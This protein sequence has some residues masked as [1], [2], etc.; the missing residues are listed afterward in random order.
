MET[1]QVPDCAEAGQVNRR[2]FLITAGLAG[3]SLFL[4]CVVDPAETLASGGEVSGKIVSL[5]AWVKIGTDDSVT[6]VVSQAEMGQGIRTTLPAVLAE[7]LGADWSR[8]RLEDSPTDPAYRNPR[9]NWQFTGNSESTPSFF[10]L[11]RQMGA[12]ARE[13]LIQAAAQRWNVDPLACRTEA[14]K[15]VHSRSHR[16][17]RFGEL[18]EAA[19]KI[20]PPAKPTLKSEK[21][22]TLLGKALPR[23]ENPNKVEGSAIFGL[24]FSL[25]GL[26]YA[27]VR[28]CPVFGGDVASVDRSSI[29]GF[30]GVIDVVR[31]P[32]GIAVVGET[33]WQAKLAL[34]ALNV[35]FSEGPAASVG[36]ESLRDDYR[37]AMEGNEWLL[38]HAEGNADALHHDYPNVPLTKDTIPIISS[39]KAVREMY[40][41]IYSQ[42]YESQFLAH[43][44]M[45][46][47]NCTARVSGDSVEIWAPTQGQELTRLTLAAVFKLPKENIQV[48]RTLLGGG[49]GRRLVAD[50]ALQAALVSKGVG[51]PVKVIWSREEDVQ[52]DIYRP[53]T[54]HRI[55]AGID[56]YGKLR[57]IAHRLV[58][59][60]ILEYVFAQAVTDVYDPSCLEGL[61][62]SHYE[63]PNVR[64]DFKLLH[65]PVPTSVLRTTGYGPNI[66][67]FESFIDELASKK[68]IDPYH[69]RR[70]LLGKSSRSLAVL[71]LAAK[72][73]DWETPAPKGHYRG[74]A[75]TEAFG[76]HLAH[77]VELSVLKERQVKI[78]K[79]ICVADPGTALDPDI[80]MNSL[81]GGI[82]WGLSCAFKSEITFERGRTVQSNWH[83]YSVLR[84]SEMPPVEVHLINSGA[85]PLGG[86]GEV[87]PITVVPAVT[88]AIF[89]A[90][91]MRFRSLP[92]SKHGFSLA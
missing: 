40:P 73:S 56:E 21:E 64:V 8:I 55:T 29:A 2:Q 74:I 7:E 52:H 25:P 85:R 48:S 51:R 10:E 18:V 84:M 34:D 13:M 28:Q 24:D 72:K 82:A 71:D 33:Y 66:F 88:N 39:M 62:E 23:V 50:F 75:Y 20:T 5:N 57:A 83:D 60:S 89:A 78:H 31:I 4:K 19:A 26:A 87:G 38:V 35:S 46:P 53:A 47:M 27:A 36:S 77:V 69:Y 79:I 6:I 49:F 80:T 15:V 44:T 9:L 68:G 61:I 45:E 22:W 42:E 37:R 16:S 17:V 63:I 3:G 11:M 41:T 58:S 54:L 67:A 65:V 86:T 91:E 90:T 43:A 30:P 70:D 81:E 14:G 76:T 92:L 1:P 59:P 32:N 12:S